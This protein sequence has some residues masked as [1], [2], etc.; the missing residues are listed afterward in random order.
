VSSQGLDEVSNQTAIKM[1]GQL[2]DPSSHLRQEFGTSRALEW[3]DILDQRHLTNSEAALLLYFRANAWANRQIERRTD[4]AAGWS[5]WSWEQPE[6]QEQVL[7]LRRAINSPGFD[8]LESFRRCQ[9][10]TNLANQL[11]TVGRFVEAVEYWDRALH[12]NAHF[13]M[14]LG[15]RGY[16]LMHYAKALYEQGH[17]AQV[18]FHAHQG[19]SAALSRKAFYECE[20]DGAK[21]FF[22][23]E[24][25]QIERVLDVDKVSKI[26]DSHDHSLGSSE[27][28]RHYRSWC[29][30]NRLFLN[31]LNDLGTQSV[32]ASDMLRL[33]SFVTPIDEPPTLIG[34]FNQLKQEFVSAR[35]LLYEGAHANDVH[36]SD[37]GVALL[38][39]MDYPCYALAVEK[40]KAAFRIGYSI[41]DKIGFFLNDYMNLGIDLNKVYFRS[42]WYQKQKADAGA[43]RPEFESSENWPF[44]GLFWLSKDF[45]DEDFSA[46]TEPDAQ[47]LYEIRNQLEHKY[48]KVH[49]MPLPR[50]N[51]ESSELWRIDRLAYSVER[52]DLEAKT[53]RLLKLARAGLI[54]LSLGMNRMEQIRAKTKDESQIA[55]M[56]LEPWD[57]A[58]KL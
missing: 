20:Y 15:N 17:R 39:T 26:I 45:F 38:N 36:F 23:A 7:H 40:V 33:P 18:F 19:L 41:F 10:L 48:L 42:V 49:E 54:Y 47:A 21:R 1:I 43:I 24:K 53:A 28:E 25:A 9:I 5:G 37:R 16:G 27:E 57:D 34:L 2:I 44:R 14:A 6:L 32:A 12:I 51:D 29:L 52:R 50:T 46:V 3:C 31:P 35:W 30:Q 4:R 56:S 58:W 22:A 11:D 55:S 8:E 13:G